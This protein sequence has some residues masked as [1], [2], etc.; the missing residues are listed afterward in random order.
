MPY[1]STYKQLGESWTFKSWGMKTCVF[2]SWTFNSL[3]LFKYSIYALKVKTSNV[4]VIRLLKWLD[5]ISN[6]IL[7][8]ALIEI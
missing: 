7:T 2:E 3:D 5:I 1:L 4:V 8:E 6:D